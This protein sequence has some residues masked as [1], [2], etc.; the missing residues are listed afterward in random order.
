MASIR[1]EILIDASPQDVW[2]AVR[3]WGALHE[4][5]VP[6]FV[7]DTCLD[8]EDRI[9]TFAN[10]TVLRERLVDLDEE[11]RRL[12]WSIVDGP[13]THHN[14]SAQVFGEG[15]NRARFVWTADLLPNELAGPTGEAMGQGTNVVKQTLEAPAAQD[16]TSAS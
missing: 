12:A 8:G 14:A 13:Y 3:D 2:A 15:E 4:R 16:D 7:L 6:G 1:K 10:G 5:L 11:T 9:V